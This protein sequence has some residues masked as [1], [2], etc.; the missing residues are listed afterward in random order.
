[1]FLHQQLLRGE[2]PPEHALVDAGR[3]NERSRGRMLRHNSERGG[4]EGLSRKIPKFSVS[5][6][7][8]CAAEGRPRGSFRVREAACLLVVDPR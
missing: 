2:Y 5:I 3:A 7:R 8:V 1:M 6:Q 4:I